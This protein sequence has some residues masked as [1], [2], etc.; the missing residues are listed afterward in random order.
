MRPALPQTWIESPVSSALGNI[1]MAGW[2][3]DTRAIS[4]ERMRVLGRRALVL[5]LSG[6][7]YYADANGVSCHLRAGDAVVV[8]PRLPHAYGTANHQP[9]EQVYAV[10]DG[11]QFDLLHGSSTFTA[12][13]PV[14]HLE[15][16]ELWHGRLEEILRPRTGESPDQ[17]LRTIGRFTDLLIEM[18]TT[19]AAA[20]RQPGDAW[21]E[22]SLRLLGEPHRNGWMAPQ[23]VARQLGQSYEA[24]RKRFAARS[25]KAPG[26]FQKQ[27]RIDLACAAIYQGED[28]FKQLAE[29]L[30]FCDVYHFSKAFRQV[31][32]IPPSAYRRTV[33]GG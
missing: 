15:P 33:R 14:W 13:L 23:A 28:N 32:G 7:G 6:H 25:G 26:Q 11:P 29:K 3:H 9:W 20:R 24:F 16:V 31:M 18:A 21:L 30:G 1:W 10:F 17:A 12:H 27:R 19:D 22:E 5:I 8:D 4:R 2:L